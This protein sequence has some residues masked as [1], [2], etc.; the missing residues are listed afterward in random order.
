LLLGAV[1]GCAEPQVAGQSLT[2]QL[3][4]TLPKMLNEVEKQSILNERNPKSHI[5]SA[6]KVAE[7]RIKNAFLLTQEGQTREATQD[8]DAYLALIVYADAYARK[9]LASKN[10]DRSHCLKRIEQAVF[11]QSRNID[12]ITRALPLES[13][14][15]A[16]AQIS[17]V[18]KIRLRAIND[19]L[20]QG[21]VISSP[22]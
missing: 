12:S 5:K 17:E 2:G 1:L 11:K 16:E 13:R 18:K 10:K 20:G 22:N 4:E 15:A 8:L 19:L 7:A 9:T 14:E 21:Q 6:L 3:T